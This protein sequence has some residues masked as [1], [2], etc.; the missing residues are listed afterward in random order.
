MRKLA[1]A[2]AL[3]AAAPATPAG[4]AVDVAQ[5][6][7][8]SPPKRLVEG[9]TFVARD[10]ARMR[11]R[12]RRAIVGFYLSL[13]RRRDGSDVRLIGSRRLERPSAKTRVTVPYAIPDGPFHLL[14]CADDRGVLRE[15]SERNNCRASKSTTRIGESE[16][17]AV[18][19]ALSD[20]SAFPDD[21]EGLMRATGFNRLR[22]PARVGGGLG[23]PAALRRLDT[24]L[25]GSAAYDRS[26]A[27]GSAADAEADGFV[28]LSAGS[29]GGSLKTL[30]RAHELEPTQARHLVN[31]AAMAAT[32]GKPAEALALLDRAERLE[33]SRTAPFGLSQRAVALNTR[34][35]ALLGLGRFAEARAALETAVGL[36]PLLAEA[37]VNLAAARIC[38]G[39]TT[40]NQRIL[41]AGQNRK[42]TFDENPEGGD[43]IKGRSPS[44]VLDLRA[45]KGAK[46]PH[47]ELPATFSQAFAMQGYYAGI[48][49][50]RQPRQA[51][52][53]ERMRQMGQRPAP[54]TTDASVKRA[55]A[56]IQMVWKAH[57]DP[58]VG[59]AYERW[60]AADQR[61]A[62][63]NYS[64]RLGEAAHR[65]SQ[66]AMAACTGRPDYDACHERVYWEKCQPESASLHT[67]WLAD[68]TA[69]QQSADAYVDAF[70]R[71][72]TALLANLAD[73][74]THEVMADELEQQLDM[75]FFPLVQQAYG[76]GAQARVCKEPVPANADGVPDM[77]LAGAEKCPPW[78]RA[79][80]IRWKWTGGR[81][82]SAK[83]P[84]WEAEIEVNCERV[85][86][87]LA[88][89]V[90]GLMDYAWLGAFAQLEYSP[91]TGKTTV[92]AGP[93]GGV[94]VPATQ[95]GGSAKDGIYVTFDAE[96][97][98]D[99]VG[100]RFT[101][102]GG[103][104][105]NPVSIKS[106]ETMDFSFV[107]VFGGGPD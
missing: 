64:M 19:T 21:D 65:W 101:A 91:H 47:L 28:A 14:A 106:G 57:E 40:G 63:G 70:H 6:S 4:A 11:G 76:W 30:L 96:G 29:P 80:R 2:V 7:V 85:K 84:P 94:K 62:G 89:A 48:L 93:K 50:K 52:R 53:Q 105:T 39:Q 26:T 66:A 15:R 24:M 104:S 68:V 77:G 31:A 27:H 83:T 22:C 54:P 69:V 79:V 49:A 107:P 81:Q 59:A 55:S 36:E 103:W 90:A 17:D 99:D 51:A 86:I 73:E 33:P 32:L 58:T 95:F 102:D 56:V 61:L 78:L 10:A 42:T 46:L 74:A 87:E 67:G 43:P 18:V 88:G 72:A 82:D 97:D 45:G 12:A 5:R 44:E 8:A 92:F 16:R 3:V 23:F 35:F 71:H 37:K 38:G 60:R 41:R 1:L 20:L 25:D 9:R 13:D 98:V 75:V 34:G 100:L